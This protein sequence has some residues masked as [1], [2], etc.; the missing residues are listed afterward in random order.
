MPPSPWGLGVHNGQVILGGWWVGGLTPWV[1]RGWVFKKG[2]G[3]WVWAWET[4][5]PSISDSMAPT[6]APVYCLSCGLTA[7]MAF[8]D[9]YGNIYVVVL[10]CPGCPF[11]LQCVPSGASATMN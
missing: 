4:R 3:G 7:K 6:K 9:S 1:M 11:C 5:P 8:G 10:S 2:A